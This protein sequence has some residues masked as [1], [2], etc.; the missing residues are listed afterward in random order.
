MLRLTLITLVTL[1]LTLQIAGQPDPDAPGPE[2]APKATPPAEPPTE[3]MILPAAA[4][5]FVDRPARHMPGPPLQPSPEHRVVAP[6]AA[7]AA[8]Y[9][10]TANRLNVRAGPTTAAPVLEQLTQGEQVLVLSDP[11]AAWVRIRI[12]GDGI[13]GWVS[14]KLLRPER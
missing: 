8:L 7:Q 9:S 3:A 6:P 4:P 11:A 5:T 13:E 14:R 1:F 10:V 2:A 12:E